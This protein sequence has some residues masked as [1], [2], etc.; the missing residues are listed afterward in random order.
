MSNTPSTHKDP[1]SIASDD[2]T[3]IRQKCR[4]LA[5][6]HDS[7]AD[8]RRTL[9]ERTKDVADRLKEERLQYQTL[10][11]E[12][13]EFMEARN[14]SAF[15]NESKTLRITLVHKKKKAP[16]TEEFMANLTDEYI[17]QHG[18]IT[19]ANRAAFMEFVEAARETDETKVSV[20]KTGSHHK[21]KPADDASEEPEAAADADD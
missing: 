12:I 19:R 6:L 15:Q 17:Q 10:L 13:R 16:L 1:M 9:K 14:T 20:R 11:E 8:R 3:S 5:Q 21:K 18:P 2:L 4:V 7:I